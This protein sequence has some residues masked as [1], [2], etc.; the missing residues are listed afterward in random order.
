MA[1]VVNRGRDVDHG[2]DRKANVDPQKWLSQAPKVSD[3]LKKGLFASVTT[4]GGRDIA[5]LVCD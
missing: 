2:D 5:G 4:W 1:I 3:A